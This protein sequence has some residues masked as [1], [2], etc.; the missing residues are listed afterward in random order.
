MYRAQL[1]D[2]GEPIKDGK[3]IKHIMTHRPPEYAPFVSS[4]NTHKLTMGSAFTKPS[5][6][7]FSEMLALEHDN[8]V[9]M[10][11]L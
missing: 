11:I 1:K 10:V 4:Y 5:F 2:Y 6:K 3:M 8:L 7:K 9:S